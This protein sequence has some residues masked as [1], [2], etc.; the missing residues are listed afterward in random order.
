MSSHEVNPFSSQYATEL[1]RSTSFSSD[2]ASEQTAS[3]YKLNEP[4]PTLELQRIR[5][6]T[7]EDFENFLVNRP[8]TTDQALK[9]F[10]ALSD[11]GNQED[12]DRVLV[13]LEALSEL[14]AKIKHDGSQAEGMY[15]PVTKD[16]KP[17]QG[18]GPGV[19]HSVMDH[20][21]VQYFAAIEPQLANVMRA[22]A[23]IQIQEASK[24]S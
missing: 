22:F 17:D 8:S 24:K 18:P 2:T 9:S 10:Y 13:F 4:W 6:L 15:V 16:G 21:S 7:L 1:P 14:L 12:K 20:E 3:F 23:F 19:T 11:E 5:Y